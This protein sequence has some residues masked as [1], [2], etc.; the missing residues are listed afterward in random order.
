[1]SKKLVLLCIILSLSIV[2]FPSKEITDMSTPAKP[3]L[4]TMASPKKGQI[5]LKWKKEFSANIEVYISKS[6]T[7]NKNTKSRLY[8][9]NV[10]TAVISGWESSTY[11]YAK[12][13]AYRVSSSG[14]KVYSSW[15]N[16]LSVKVK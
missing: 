3:T 5:S 15:S 6:K 4:K 13:R 8:S 16:V 7:F 1:M 12:V 11:Y 10:T 9:N 14:K 2:V